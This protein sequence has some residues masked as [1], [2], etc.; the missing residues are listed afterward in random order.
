MINQS[1]TQNIELSILLIFLPFFAPL[2]DLMKINK[3]RCEENQC[4]PQ[5]VFIFHCFAQ[6]GMLQENRTWHVVYA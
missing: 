4:T 6:L 3:I 2:N 5:N 1:F